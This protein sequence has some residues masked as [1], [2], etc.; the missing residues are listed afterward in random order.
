MKW[1]NYRIKPKKG[2]LHY[3]CDCETSDNAP[4]A[5]NWSGVIKW[6]TTKK[7]VLCDG[8]FCLIRKHHNGAVQISKIKIALEMA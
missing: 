7:R 2:N 6:L 5:L 4:L 8:K 1:V 3:L